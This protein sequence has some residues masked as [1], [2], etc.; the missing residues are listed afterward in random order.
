MT[1]LCAR[2]PAL[3]GKGDQLRAHQ[4][5]LALAG[6][7]DVTVAC[8]DAGPA[9]DGPQGC[10]V[11]MAR[12]S[13]FARAA[14]ALDALVRG[15]PL[16]VGYMMPRAAWR[17]LRREAERADLVLA[18]TVRAVREPLDVPLVIDHV[19]ALSRNMRRRSRGPEPWP[20]R[21]VFRIEARLLRRYEQR[22]A[23]H[24]VAQVVISQVDAAALPDA[25]T[26]HVVPNTVDLPP[27][28]LDAPRDTDVIF[29]GNMRYPPNLDAAR[30]LRAEIVPALLE[31]RPQTSIVV[32]GR[33]ARTLDPWPGVEIHSDV[34]DLI[35]HIRR[36]RIAVVPLRLGT[37]AA[38]KVL[39]AI[40]AGAVVV[41]TADA[42][43]PFGLAGDAAV[44]ADDAQ[45]IASEIVALLDDPQRL[46]AMRVSAAAQL[47]RFTPAALG[48][49]LDEVLA[50]AGWAGP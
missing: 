24:A 19:D 50:V 32:A 11:V 9:G 2:R 12:C 22:I 3:G 25:P 26:M 27:I 47:S 10:S 31:R 17:A 23:R 41:G 36:T 15:Q 38:N 40:A 39:E 42:L 8:T 13:R 43:E 30:W 1:I 34:P 20:F 21:L 6:R 35:A 29:T 4:F 37:G 5:A 14:G 46:D 44:A 48:T 28:E 45:A 7:H 33:D 18:L 49:A 16:Q